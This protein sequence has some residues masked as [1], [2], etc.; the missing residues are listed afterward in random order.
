[1]TVYAAF[2]NACATYG[3]RPFLHIPP[4]ATAGYQDGPVDLSYGEA[5]ERVGSLRGRYRDAGYAHAQRV[6]LVLENRAELFLHFLALNS[7]GVSIVPVNAD[8]GPQEMSYVI[9][10]SDACLIVT[11]S[12]HE[13]KVRE[14]K[15][16]VP[17]VA[18]DRMEDLPEAT[19]VRIPGEP[20]AAAEAALLYTSGTTGQPKGCMLSNAYFWCMG[21]WYARLGGY[22]VLDP[23]TER[24]LTPLPLVHMNAL[25]CSTMAMILSGGCIVQLDRFRAS[26]WWQCV[27][28][29]R[30]TI[31]HYLGV[32]PAILLNL[33]ESDDE[34]FGDQIKFGFGAGV[35][36]RHQPIFERRFGFPLIEGWAMTETGIEVSIACN[37]EP[38]HAADSRR[39]RQSCSVGRPGRCL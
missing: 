11:L 14:A 39:G 22:C 12:E 25:A 35:D 36:P 24:L 30:A 26:T 29:S 7:L 16:P 3:E 2:E 28:E 8:F 23:G 20:D 34:D 5:L 27:R 33:P 38:R 10:H 1:M 32:M 4:Q 37:E 19:A 13:A 17:V 6:A 18:T 31:L 9:S 15:A 21:R